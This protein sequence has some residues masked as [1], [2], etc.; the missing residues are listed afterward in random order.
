MAVFFI[1]QIRTFEIKIKTQCQKIKK[2]FTQ[3]L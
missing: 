1:I 2:G 3:E